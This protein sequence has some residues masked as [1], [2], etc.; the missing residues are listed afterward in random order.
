MLFAGC[1]MIVMNG[2]VINNQPQNQANINIAQI[3]NLKT[4]SDMTQIA[5][6]WE[7]ASDES[8]EGYILYRNDNINTNNF[9][10]IATINDRYATHY[11][12]SGLKPASIYQYTMS[13]YSK[14]GEGQKSQIYTISTQNLIPDRKSVV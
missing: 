8:V 14:Q 1:L 6:E 4:I 12:D 10:K 7:R 3:T 13:A 11:V 5:F 9:K 2:C